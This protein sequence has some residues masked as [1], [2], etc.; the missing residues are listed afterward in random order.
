MWLNIANAE[1]IIAS[2]APP[3]PSQYIGSWNAVVFQVDH[4][5]ALMDDSLHIKT[6]SVPIIFHLGI[7]SEADIAGLL[8]N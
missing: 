4:C 8:G 1:H 3:Q 5:H 7:M 2:P 6:H